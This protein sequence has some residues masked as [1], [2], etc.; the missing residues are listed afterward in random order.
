LALLI[1]FAAIPIANK[2]LPR[3]YAPYQLQM[4]FPTLSTHHEYF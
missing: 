2:I 3:S 4:R 1:Q